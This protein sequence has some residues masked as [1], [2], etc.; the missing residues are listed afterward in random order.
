MNN[1]LLSN[2]LISPRFSSPYQTLTLSLPLYH[3]NIISVCIGSWLHKGT[4]ITD[5]FTTFVEVFLG[6]LPK[7]ETVGLTI[8]TVIVDRFGLSLDEGVHAGGFSGDSFKTFGGLNLVGRVVASPGIIFGS[9]IYSRHS[10]PTNSPLMP[11]GKGCALP[12]DSMLSYSPITSS[13]RCFGESTPIQKTI[14]QNFVEGWPLFLL[15]RQ[16]FLDQR[17][18]VSRHMSLK[19]ERHH[20]NLLQNF[21]GGLSRVW[22]LIME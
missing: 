13:P 3:T 11:I 18:G 7:Y 9:S 17:S 12:R 2:N 19:F 5:I 14:A 20:L 4:I 22:L 6:G 8:R 16:N 10:K 21:T 1:F 15:N